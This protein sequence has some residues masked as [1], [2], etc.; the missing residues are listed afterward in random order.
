MVH[1]VSSNMDL[2]RAFS[3]DGR[4]VGYKIVYLVFFIV[5]IT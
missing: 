4:I 3:Y 1:G 5:V 2:R